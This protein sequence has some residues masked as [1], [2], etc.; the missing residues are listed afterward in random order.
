MVILKK[1]KSLLKLV[2]DLFMVIRIFI[3]GSRLACL[4]LIISNVILIVLVMR[5]ISLIAILVIIRDLDSFLF[6]DCNFFGLLV[7]KN[8]ISLISLFIYGLLVMGVTV[9]LLINN[10]RNHLVSRHLILLLTSPA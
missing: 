8:I 2:A 1:L 10:L 4:W 9:N 3:L 6:L 5:T 7:M